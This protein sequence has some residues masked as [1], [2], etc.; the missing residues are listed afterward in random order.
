MSVTSFGPFSFDATSGSLSREGKPVAIGTRGAA[1]LAA[2]IAADGAPVAK[3]AL[4]EA[5][6]PD[7]T[8]EEGNLSVQIATLRKAMGPRPDGLDWIATVPRVGY[9]W[10]KETA[11]QGEATGQVLPSLAVLPFQNL[12]GDPEQD[13]FA[14]GIVE[15]VITALSRYRSFAVIARNSSFVYKDRAVDVR[16]IASELGARYVLEGSVRKAG[17]KLRINAQLIDAPTG[18]HLWAE[19]FDGLVGDIFD[20]QDEITASVAAI[21]EPQ[22]SRAEIERSRRE[23]PESLDAYDLFLRGIAKL[24]TFDPSQSADGLRLLDQSIAIDP[25]NN[26]AVAMAAWGYE[27][28][29]HMG[30][31]Q[32]GPD[33]FERCLTLARRALA[34]AGDDAHVIAHCGIIIQLCSH[35]WELGL[36]TIEHAIALNPASVLTNFFGGVGHYKG[37]ELDRA[38]AYFER[39]IAL[40]PAQSANSRAGIAQLHLLHGRYRE[41]M[42]WSSRALAMNPNFGWIHMLLLASL[43]YLGRHDEAAR[44]LA[45]S[46][47]VFPDVTLAGI[48][49]G[50]VTRDPGRSAILFEGLRRAGLPES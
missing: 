44:A 20:F 37:G 36:Q 23:R 40:N 50:Q 3:D 11:P 48:R 28:R 33:D 9:R 27:H 49:R 14:D 17:N 7:A 24:N 38:Q 26:L 31:P 29:L 13:Y 10:L 35:E 19:H 25:R 42:D 34:E 45:T 47:R 46:R 4:L 16:T 8:V 18:A 39:A 2:L 21:V 30:L 43:A 6:W 41:A 15:D 1:L 12:S 32:L 5:G 22:I